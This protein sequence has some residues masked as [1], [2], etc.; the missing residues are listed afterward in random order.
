[1]QREIEEQIKTYKENIGLREKENNTSGE[2]SD[3]ALEFNPLR[4]FKKRN[5]AHLTQ[6]V[7]KK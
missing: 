1:M 4:K 7:K 2:E 6:I 3:G 5:T